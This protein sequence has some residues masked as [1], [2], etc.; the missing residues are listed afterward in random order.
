MAE[1]EIAEETRRREDAANHP[2]VKAVLEAFP[3]S[4]VELV[5][6]VAPDESEDPNESE[7]IDVDLELTPG[8][9]ES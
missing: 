8:E 4:G 5:R 3:G 6:D 2:L 1:Q 9:E 7:E